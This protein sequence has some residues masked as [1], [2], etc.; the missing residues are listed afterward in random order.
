MQLH[1]IIR[2]KLVLILKGEG[3]AVVAWIVLL[4]LN[5][6]VSP[7]REW[8]EMNDLFF[9]ERF[10]NK[11]HSVDSNT[12]TEPGASAVEKL[13]VIDIQD[14]TEE[15]KS[16]GEY[17]WMIGKLDTAK[18]ACIGIDI[19]FPDTREWD[20]NGEEQFVEAVKN[21][22]RVVL[23]IKFV[24]AANQDT[25]Y[26]L[27]KNHL[28]KNFALNKKDVQSF[29]KLTSAQVELPF[30]N[31][32]LVVKH[33]GH[34]SFRREKYHL[35]PLMMECDNNA[36]P[37]FAYEVARVYSEHKNSALKITN[38]PTESYAQMFVNFIPFQKFKYYSLKDARPL[39]QADSLSFRDK[40][41][42]IVNSSPELPLAGTPLLGNKPY[43]LWALHAS[44]ICQILDNSNIGY[45]WKT[46]LFFA[47]GLLFCALI[48][49]LFVS[50]RYT[51]R[52]RK[53]RWPIII[54]HGVLV[55]L[56]FLFLQV[57]YWVGVMTPIFIFTIGVVAIR[58]QFH[59]IYQ[60][61]DYENFSINVTE[62]MR[63][64][65]PVSV[66]YTPAGEDN[67]NIAF[68]RFFKDKSFIGM[69][70]N[71]E[72]LTADRHDILQTGETLYNA[73]FQ[74]SLETRLFQCVEIIKREN[75]R[76]RIRLRLDAPEVSDLPWEYMYGKNLSISFLALDQNVS[77]TR[78]I[79]FTK[80]SE[81]KEYRAPLKILVVIAKPTDLQILNTGDEKK[82]LKKS[83]LTLRLLRQVK[84]SFCENATLEKLGTQIR[85]EKY[86]VLHYI[87][88][89]EFDKKK[90]EGLLLL[91]KEDGESHAVE[92]GA[93]AMN[94][95]NS[96]I[97][98]VILN[99]CEG[100][101][102]EKSNAFLGVAQALVKGGV[103][104]VVAMQ[105]KIL[106]DIALLFS[107]AFYTSFLTNFSIDA[108]IADA[109]HAIMNR[110][111][112]SRQ[113]WGTPVLFMR[114]DGAKIFG[115]RSAR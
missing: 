67:D 110:V 28:E 23:P 100:A 34:I 36:Y 95:Q 89:G 74:Q 42:L 37:A 101:K 85:S 2:K 87:G 83:L 11:K 56:V 69:Q 49:I 96:S 8:R 65:Y 39:L 63:G 46:P 5:R 82:S 14:P 20:K 12:H 53:V 115:M 24:Q 43:P 76:L 38:I 102:G 60:P 105:H 21:C 72:E 73:I 13:V 98:L 93:I 81:P 25:S 90:G 114:A 15:K 52:W 16:R 57:E 27:A 50:E 61:P 18:A 99:S 51:A 41:V 77:I 79:P 54:C 84:L 30:Y 9:Y 26:S 112:L 19:R 10:S 1:P 111:G 109:R 94:L 59:D 55:L 88:H 113:D 4:L 103:P 80:P 17:A 68:S 104:A 108:A 97:R 31:L 66:A 58:N 92:A 44:L 91:E 29:S 71:F 106:D 70:R 62:A 7:V 35:F 75:K 40:I 22:P 107:Q 33:V 47:L 45:S 48:W 3:Y 86:D 64:H 32:F 6:Y 78:Y